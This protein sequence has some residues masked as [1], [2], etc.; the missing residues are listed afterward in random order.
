MINYRDKPGH[1]L[2]NWLN[3]IC[4]MLN[5]MG[6][7]AHKNHPERSYSGKYLAGEPFDYEFF[8]NGKVYCFDAKENFSGGAFWR[9]K[10]TGSRGQ[11]TRNRILRQSQNLLACKRNGAEG[12]FLV[13]FNNIKYN[14]PYS[15]VKYDCEAVYN[16]LC[17]DVQK[18]SFSE[19]TRFELENLIRKGS[20]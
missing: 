11:V 17:Q 20:A 7:H 5:G 14:L 19:G 16:A 3:Q 12:F 9:L 8:I 15:L 10:M 18:L 4:E 13:A 6:Y 1:Q 2:E